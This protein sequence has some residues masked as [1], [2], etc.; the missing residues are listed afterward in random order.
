MRSNDFDAIRAL[1]VTF[2]SRPPSSA[3][4]DVPPRLS[5]MP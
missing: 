1:I 3:A 5:K 2:R 4:A